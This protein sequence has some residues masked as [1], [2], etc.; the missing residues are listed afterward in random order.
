VCLALLAVRRGTELDTTQHDVG[1]GQGTVP[2][3]G[4]LPARET[5]AAG[6]ACGTP[7]GSE[8]SLA[9]QSLRAALCVVCA[10]AL[11]LCLPLFASLCLLFLSR[12]LPLD[13]LHCRCCH[14]RCLASPRL[15][16]SVLPP[17]LSRLLHLGP[18]PPSRPLRP[19]AARIRTP[20]HCCL[21]RCLWPSSSTRWP[22]GAGV[23]SLSHLSLSHSL[24][25]ASSGSDSSSTAAAAAAPWSS[26]LPWPAI[27]QHGVGTTTHPQLSRP[28]IHII[29]T[30]V[31]MRRLISQSLPDVASSSAVITTLLSPPSLV[32][33]FLF[34]HLWLKPI[35]VL[36]HT[37][38]TYC[39]N[40]RLQPPTHT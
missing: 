9:Q 28:C 35:A 5:G 17:P 3:L 37:Y 22:Y 32:R 27:T 18:L 33:Y 21:L 2:S 1:P 39:R 15:T 38:H 19:R 23:G 14:C 16:W 10:N 40:K 20:V 7:R 29:P 8:V 6:T 4:T 36:Y 30:Y 31:S 11:R 13:R 34:L 24:Y 26:A 12:C 25:I